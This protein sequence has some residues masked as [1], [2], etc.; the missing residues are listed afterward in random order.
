MSGASG[1]NATG[2]KA[3]LLWWAASAILLAAIFIS[4]VLRSNALPAWAGAYPTTPVNTRPYFDAVSETLIANPIDL[5]ISGK[6]NPTGFLFSVTDDDEVD[7][8]ILDID[9]LDRFQP[10]WQP[11]AA[12]LARP[13]YYRSQ[14]GL[15]GRAYS[16]AAARMGL[17]RDATFAAFRMFAAAALA[18]VL[19]VI[20]AFIFSLWGTGPAAAALAFCAFATGFNLFAP[21]LHWVAFVH[22]A[23]TAVTAWLASR[24]PTASW[25]TRIGAFALAAAF[26][27]AKFSCGYEFTTTTIAAAVVPFFVAFAAGRIALATLVRYAVAVLAVGV[28]GF[29][30]VFT[31]HHFMHLAAF[32]QSGFGWMAQRSAVWGGVPLVGPLGQFGQIAKVLAVNAVDIN[33]F[34]VPNALV[35]LAGLPFLFIAAKALLLREFDVERTRVAA[36]VAAAFLASASWPLLQFP[37]ISFHPRFSAILVSFP[38]GL[39]LSAGLARLWQLRRGAVASSAAPARPA[40]SPTHSPG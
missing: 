38:F 26:M 11:D 3:S 27:M 30:A 34:G 15:Q 22:V 29:A 33:G 35:L 37:H 32:G 24:L 36:V 13:S 2:T 14:I 8:R 21:S 5:A 17:D 28:A 25:P 16:F 23:P 10:R 1:R 7:P 40:F 18:A 39:F 19:A 9:R 20:V 4:G 6:R 31:V 12:A